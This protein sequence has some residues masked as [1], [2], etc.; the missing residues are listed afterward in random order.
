MGTRINA[1]DIE[2]YAINTSQF[3][4]VQME[5]GRE[6][7]RIPNHGAWVRHIERIVMPRYWREIGHAFTSYEDRHIAAHNLCE[8]YKR[9]A[10]EEKRA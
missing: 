7:L 8:Y 2:L 4:K 3:Y 10:E 1:E 5:L 9:A 6:A